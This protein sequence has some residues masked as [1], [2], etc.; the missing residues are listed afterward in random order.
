MR[1]LSDKEK[2]KLRLGI[3]PF[4]G[5]QQW[6]E[7]PHGGLCTNIFCKHC[8]VGINIGPGDFSELIKEPNAKVLIKILEARVWVYRY[9]AWVLS[10]IATAELVVIA[11]LLYQ[12]VVRQPS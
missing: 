8:D 1:D 4:C 12:F 9:Q 6:F 5:S 10:G 2:A 7:G 3:C 11:I